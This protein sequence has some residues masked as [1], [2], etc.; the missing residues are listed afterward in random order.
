MKQ[1]AGHVGAEVA[2]SPSMLNRNEGSARGPQVV[3]FS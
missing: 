3:P 1:V 2:G